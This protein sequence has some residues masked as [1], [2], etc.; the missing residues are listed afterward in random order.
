MELSK[1]VYRELSHILDQLSI[2]DRLKAIMVDDPRITII[3]QLTKR[4][5]ISAEENIR[6]TTA[7]SL[8]QLS[9]DLHEDVSNLETIKNAEPILLGDQL[10]ARYYQLLVEH[11]QLQLI[12]RLARA[13]KNVNQFKIQLIE[14]SKKECEFLFTMKVRIETELIIHLMR[15]VGVSDLEAYYSQLYSSHLL[16]FE[17]EKIKTTN[18]M[19]AFRIDQLLKS[20][21]T[22]MIR[23]S[24]QLK[25]S[26]KKIATQ[27]KIAFNRSFKK[28]KEKQMNLNN[29]FF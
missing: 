22:S 23:L 29:S 9:L 12:N 21:E 15:Y 20:S 2:D 26:T 19:N 27:I 18:Q 13:T 25:P 6:I 1:Y 10:A 28:H 3:S 8:L 4:L 17:R 24:K 5:Q 14:S 16:Q 11:E 7:I